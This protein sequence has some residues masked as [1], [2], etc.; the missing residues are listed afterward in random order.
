VNESP[1]TNPPTRRSE[2]A[3]RTVMMPAHTNPQGAI[4]GGVILSLIDEA[5]FVEALRQRNHNYVTVA[6]NGVEFHKPVLVGDVLS[7]YAETTRV[8][9]T[10]LTVRVNVRAFRPEADQ[11]IDVTSAEVVLVAVDHA[12]QPVPIGHCAAREHL[13]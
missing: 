1:Q 13:G 12:G 11:T 5:A 4:F 9:R 6:F 7:L 10:S 3:I 8:G 2:V